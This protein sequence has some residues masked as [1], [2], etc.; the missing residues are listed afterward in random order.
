MNPKTAEVRLVN[1][2]IN[3]FDSI[4]NGTYEWKDE[5]VVAVY[6]LATKILKDYK[7]LNSNYREDMLN[8]MTMEFF[9]KVSKT[10]INRE[11][12]LS[13]FIYSIMKNKLLMYVNQ[14][15]KIYDNETNILDRKI[16][17]LET[18]SSLINNIESTYLDSYKKLFEDEK[19]EYYT[20]LRQEASKNYLLNA[21]FI[22]NKTQLQIAKEVGIS[23]Q[24]INYKMADEI[25]A[26]K[27]KCIQSGYTS[28]ITMPNVEQK[29]QYYF[30]EKLINQYGILYLIYNEKMNSDFIATS[31]NIKLSSINKAIESTLKDKE[32]QLENR[33][34]N[35]PKMYI[36]FTKRYLPDLLYKIEKQNKKYFDFVYEIVSEEEILIKLF[37]EGKS[38]KQIFEEMDEKDSKLCK[39]IYNR[40]ESFKKTIVNK[41]NSHTNNRK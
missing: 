14:I 7:L 20:F 22:E 16:S 1:V 5:E 38:P 34:I 32:M 18:P 25:D 4:K 9:C 24:R 19:R 37:K 41:Y 39:N 31:L 17:C 11:S 33:G 27:I 26:L 10:D 21:Y 3:N 36:E 29:E 35:N 30:M 12:G 8:V 40:I 13:S 28:N 15:N 23:P 2:I 6:K